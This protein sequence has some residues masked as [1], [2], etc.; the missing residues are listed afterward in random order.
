MKLDYEN[1]LYYFKEYV[2]EQ[3]R[4]TSEHERLMG[5]NQKVLH[6][7]D[8]VDSGEDIAK[9]LKFNSSVTELLKIALLDHDIGRFLQMRVIGTYK[10]YD[11]K[12]SG[13]CNVENHGELGEKVL[14]GGNFTLPNG[15][16]LEQYSLL[17]RQLLKNRLFDD[18]ILSVVRNHVDNIS[19]T[20]DLLILTKKILKNEDITDIFMSADSKTIKSII[21]AFTQIVQDVDRLDIYYQ[22]LDDRFICKKTDEEINSVVFDKF[23]N[24]EYLNI[25]ELKCQ[26]L[27]NSNVGELVRLSFINQIRLLSVI[28]KIKNEQIIEKLKC[29]N[30][31]KKVLDAYDFTIEKINKI[32]NSSEDGVTTSYVKKKSI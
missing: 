24:G 12:Q 27:W 1:A 14:I 21:S 15:E 10:D 6:T 19:D 25:N 22:I 5:I 30:D 9:S 7:L 29:K 18:C 26:G 23:Y 28:E 17:K 32:I 13:F 16:V 20:K 11:L 8:V 2:L 3:K 4:E 31:N